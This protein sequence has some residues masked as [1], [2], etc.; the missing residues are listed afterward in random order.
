[1]IVRIYLYES[2]SWITIIR[3][4]FQRRYG[5]TEFQPWLKSRPL[6]LSE[7]NSCIIKLLSPRVH[8]N[9]EV[10]Y[11]NLLPISDNFVSDEIDLTSFRIAISPFVNLIYRNCI[12]SKYQNNLFA[13]WNA[14]TYKPVQY[15]FPRLT[16]WNMASSTSN[17]TLLTHSKRIPVFQFKSQPTPKHQSHQ[18]TALSKTPSP[19]GKKQPVKLPFFPTQQRSGMYTNCKHTAGTVMS[20]RGERGK[21]GRGIRYVRRSSTRKFHS[22]TPMHSVYNSTCCCSARAFH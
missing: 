12:K 18:I 20:A 19:A 2:Y 17:K 6:T 10:K 9:R 3:L 8:S 13:N 7:K 22:I 4:Q 1:M 21:T 16:P 5:W 14:I 15:N 11:F